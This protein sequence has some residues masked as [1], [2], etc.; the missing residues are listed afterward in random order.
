MKKWFAMMAA[1][2][3]VYLSGVW[4]MSQFAVMLGVLGMVF[5]AVAAVT[6]GQTSNDIEGA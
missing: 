4:W 1:M 6:S 5:C 3:V 2:F